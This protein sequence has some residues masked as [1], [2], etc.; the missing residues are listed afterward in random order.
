MNTLKRILL[1]SS[2]VAGL[3]GCGP[4]GGQ[5]TAD[6]GAGGTGAAPADAGPPTGSAQFI[7]VWKFVSLDARITC[8]DGTDFPLNTVPGTGPLHARDDGN[9]GDR[10]RRAKGCASDCQVSGNAA[11]CRTD[12]SICGGEGTVD[13]DVYTYA[14]GTLS[15]YQSVRFLSPHELRLRRERHRAADSRR[16][17]SQPP[18]EPIMFTSSAIARRFT[19][20]SL[21]AALALTAPACYGDGSTSGDDG[22][23][24]AGTVV[25][26]PKAPIDVCGAIAAFPGWGK[27]APLPE[28]NAQGGDTVWYVAIPI[29]DSD[30]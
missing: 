1:V 9:P 18:K 12:L 29:T 3:A 15:E 10:R 13:E 11:S 24:T 2:L 6:A 7:G 14:A 19:R 30:Q 23:S 25:D 22:Q 5:M 4:G 20:I 17:T 26:P 8:S 27:V 21:V 16:V 28:R